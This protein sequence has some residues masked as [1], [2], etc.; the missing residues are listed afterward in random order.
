MKSFGVCPLDV[1]HQGGKNEGDS[2]SKLEGDADSGRK[3]EGA[4]LLVGRGDKL[5]LDT[6]SEN[7][8]SFQVLVLHHRGLFY[9]RPIK[10]QYQ[11]HLHVYCQS[12]LQLQY[13]IYLLLLKEV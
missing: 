13:F 10:E 7:M 4:L 6:S 9:E 5:E 2:G 1:T 8:N 3:L 11:S 12:H